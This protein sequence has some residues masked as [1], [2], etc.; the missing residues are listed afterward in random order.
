MRLVKM[1]LVGIDEAG[2]GPCLGPLVVGGF[3]LPEK[4]LDLLAEYGIKD[5]K[6]L[7]NEKREDC[8]NWLNNKAE[9]RGWRIQKLLALP[10]HID[11][12]MENR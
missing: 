4:D 6:L 1:M 5:S 9:E 7:S 8:F 12:W 3:A 11:N 10:E 2:R